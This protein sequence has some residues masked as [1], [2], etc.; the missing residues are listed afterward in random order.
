MQCLGYQDEVQLALGVV[1]QHGDYECQPPELPE[2][3]DVVNSFRCGNFVVL[4][5][6]FVDETEVDFVVAVGVLY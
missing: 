1:V 2:A 3:V 4:P 6:V 5:Y